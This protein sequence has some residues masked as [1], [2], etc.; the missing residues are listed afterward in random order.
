MK[1]TRKGS[2]LSQT[3]LQSASWRRQQKHPANAPA[4]GYSTIVKGQRKLPHGRFSRAIR[5]INSRRWLAVR[6]CRAFRARLESYFRAVSPRCQA[7]SESRVTSRA[8]RIRFF[9]PTLLALRA[10][11][12]HWS[13]LNCGRRPNCSWSTRTSSWRYSMASC[14]RRFI[15]PAM[16][17]TTTESGFPIANF[18]VLVQFAPPV[19]S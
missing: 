17:V 7:G 5:R 15:Q 12:S 1:L 3:V 16:Q 8:R 13:S 6:G 14:W 2:G 11:R 18:I 9:R 4:K 10:K 19:A